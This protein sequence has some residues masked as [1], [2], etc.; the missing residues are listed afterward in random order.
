MA[1]KDEHVDNDWPGY[2]APQP[3]HGHRWMNIERH[4]R[5]QYARNDVAYLPM[6]CQH[7]TNAHCVKAA[8]GAIT[9]RP[10]GIVMIDPVKAKGRKDL[11]DSCPFGAIYWNEEANVPQKCTM[12]AHLLDDKDWKPGMPRCVHSCPTEAMK[13]YFVEPAE[14]DKIIQQEGLAGFR[15]TELKN[16]PHVWYKNLYKYT[17]NFITAGVL[18]NGDCLENA[19]VKISGPAGYAATRTTNFFGEFKF[20][21]LEN[22]EYTVNVDAGG[23][24]KSCK[25]V[26][27]D[28]SK[29]LGFIEFKTGR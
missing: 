4:E 26:I 20:D 24:Q 13:Y 12:C 22:G 27:Q 9:Y 29:N 16:A 28:E 1:C 3:R 2:T 5:G 19:T 23:Q 25:V 18:M 17:K 6:P 10:D 7:C 21:G 14:F 11:V 15:T 8:D